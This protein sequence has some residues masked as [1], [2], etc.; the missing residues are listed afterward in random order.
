MSDE[1]EIEQRLI[2][3]EQTA[4]VIKLLATIAGALIALVFAVVFK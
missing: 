3:Q 2:E 1:W 4:Q